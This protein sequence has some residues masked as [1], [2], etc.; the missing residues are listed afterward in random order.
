MNTLD[1]K[2]TVPVPVQGTPEATGQLDDLLALMARLRVDCPWDKKQSNHSLIPYA[3]EEAY[4]LGEAVQSDDDEDIKG[5]LGDVL[6]QVVFHCQMYAEQGRFDMSDVITTLQEKLIRRHPHVFEAENLKDDA[7]VKVRWDEIKAEEQ[8]A[9]E[10]R[11]KPKRR[12][13]NTKVGS[14]LMQAQDVQKQASKLGFDWEGIAGA[15]DKLDEEIAELKSELTDKSKEAAKYDISKANIR[16]VEK[17]LGDCMFALV[18][19]ARKLN[20]DAETATLTCVHK[21]K[22]RF[23]YIEAQLDAA[24]KRLE[25]S[26]ITEMDALWEAAKQHERSS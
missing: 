10:A 21:F 24:G 20:L 26:D 15:V 4:E 1:N 6:L 3:I 7:A 16:E 11:G 22:S 23:G 2:I 18:N 5:E 25:D 17:E 9:R 12:L 19:V 8:H 13:D 14:A